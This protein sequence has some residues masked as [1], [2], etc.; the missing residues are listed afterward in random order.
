MSYHVEIECATMCADVTASS[1]V[2]VAARIADLLEPGAAYNRRAT[3]TGRIFRKLQSRLKSHGRAEI[4]NAK[5]RVLV[6]PLH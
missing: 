4:V 5:F 2:D 3:L 1:L 6:M